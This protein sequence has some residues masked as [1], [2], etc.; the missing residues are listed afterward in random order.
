LLAAAGSLGLADL[1]FTTAGQSSLQ[2]T[3]PVLHSNPGSAKTLYLNF[4]GNTITEDFAANTFGVDRNLNGLVTHPFDIDGD[5]SSF[6]GT[7]Q[8]MIR[9]IWEIVAEDYRPF[10][11]DVTTSYEGTFGDGVA[12]N[13]AI[14]GTTR[15]DE[16]T[17]GYAPVG[18]F[19]NERSNTAL[20][21]TTNIARYTH[22]EWYDT[23]QAIGN[24][25]SHESGHLFG[26]E[27]DHNL[28]VANHKSEAFQYDD[29]TDTWTPIM[30]NNISADR[31]TWSYATIG[32]SDS[33]RQD[34]LQVLAEVLGLRADDHGDSNE[35]ATPM[36][37][38]NPG[39]SFVQTGVIGTMD[40][41][42]VFSFHVQY[43]AEY[44][45]RVD[46]P[47]FG[48]LDARFTLSTADGIV[49]VVDGHIG[50]G[51]LDEQFDFKLEP[52]T[53]Y[54]LQVDNHNGYG[55][56]GQYQV[57]V[58][59]VVPEIGPLP[60]LDPIPDLPELDPVDP[61]PDI[62]SNPEAQSLPEVVQPV[63]DGLVDY[64][65]SWELWSAVSDVAQ[66]ETW[67]TAASPAVSYWATDVAFTQVN[68]SVFRAASTYSFMF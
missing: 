10:D 62:W 63:D 68:Y 36:T 40:D 65:P 49:R 42:D 35:L 37:E 1:P 67:Q 66:V 24:S 12:V 7:E 20:V 44:R 17:S 25:V 46:V 23:I 48:N 32:T 59:W 55:D 8:T 47:E 52:G 26:L 50:D 61:A 16:L 34:Q 57:S 11:I 31:H 51:V 2:E 3:L 28:D 29:G 64:Q 38:V 27:H 13:V 41:K 21:V 56:L 58:T 45:I 54:F 5:A 15:D 39:L 30:G 33:E 4:L 19:S 22:D 18:G 9:K 43:A 60:E 14:G 6:S 53:E